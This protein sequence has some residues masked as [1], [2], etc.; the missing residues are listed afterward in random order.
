MLL[1]PDSELWIVP[2][3]GGEAR[4]M[5]CNTGRMNS[6][7]SW[8]PNGRWLVFASKANG[9]Y[10]QMWLT[11]VD[12]AGHD[13]P[14]VVLDR[15]TTPERAANIPEFVNAAPDAIATIAERFMDDLNYVRAGTDLFNAGE[16]A[17]VEELVARDIYACRR[18]QVWRELN[19]LAEARAVLERAL[20]LNPRNAAAR[21]EL[22]QLPQVCR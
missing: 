17:R 13:S 21:R 22:D 19:R 2:G 11:H 1:Q 20:R 3:A 7:H 12:E 8:S 5:R 16:V 10:T 14:P 6:W 18:G 9:P 4:R 15:L